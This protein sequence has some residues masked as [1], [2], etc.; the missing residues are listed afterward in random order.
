MMIIVSSPS[1]AEVCLVANLQTMGPT[2]LSSAEGN[3][4]DPGSGM[5]LAARIVITSGMGNTQTGLNMLSGPIPLSELNLGD[6]YLCYYY[7]VAMQQ[8]PKPENQFS[9][10]KGTY[11]ICPIIK[12]QDKNVLRS[13]EELIENTIEPWVDEFDFSESISGEVPS[14]MAKKFTEILKKIRFE[15]NSNLDLAIKY[16]GG[17]LYDIGLIANLPEELAKTAKKIMLHPKG[18][19]ENAI[20][21]KK[22]LKT[23]Y[24]AGLVERQQ[25]D[26]GYWIIPR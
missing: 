23:L 17:S 24:Q 19:A 22:A 15:I 8:K 4:L 2:Y 26:D 7:P 13:F 25:R 20:S 6:D 14:E 1:I 18:I 10:G 16:E 3:L 11:I 9:T 5:L 21:D 12:A